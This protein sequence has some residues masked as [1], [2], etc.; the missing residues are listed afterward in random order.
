STK[1][2]PVSGNNPCPFLRALVAA[3]RLADDI[4]PLGKVAEVIV[5]AAR[6]GEGQ[7]ALPRAAV[8]GIALIAN[9]LNPAS[10]LRATLQGLR[11][12]RLR[13]GPLDK[14]GVGSGILDAHG[15]VDAA[16]L[17]RL[18][19]FAVSKKSAGGRAEPGLGPRELKRFMDANFERAAGHRRLI[20]RAL[21][22]GEWPVLLKVMG[23]AGQDGRYLS[24]KEVEMLF[25]KRLLPERMR[26]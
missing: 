3:G 25:N 21:M 20:D 4:E 23:K 26:A 10:V 19:E 6:H 12:N 16:Q 14:K 7:P 11:L 1:P 17:A 22:N 8:A 5:E 2:L 9:G 15:E 13:G 24:L 18:R